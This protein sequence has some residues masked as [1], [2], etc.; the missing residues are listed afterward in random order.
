MYPIETNPLIWGVGPLRSDQIL[1]TADWVCLKGAK[2][3][4]VYIT[5]IGANAT[6][7]TLTVHESVDGSGTTA[8]AVA[9]PIYTNLLTTTA[10][11][12]TR[13]TDAITYDLVPSAVAKMVAFY[14]DAATLTAGCDWIQ[15]G[16]SAG[17]ASNIGIVQYQLVGARYQ[18]AAPPTAIA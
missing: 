6:T 14:I 11:T 5:E 17:H 13:L 7:M 16:A 3:V 15:L 1:D 12:W 9:W 4:W 18:Q 10:D 2:G 8:L